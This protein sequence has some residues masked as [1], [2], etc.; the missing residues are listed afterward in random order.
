MNHRLILAVYSMLILFASGTGIAVSLDSETDTLAPSSPFI[1]ED[2]PKAM[3]GEGPLTEEILG[4]WLAEALRKT[5]IFLTPGA[6]DAAYGKLIPG[7][8]GKEEMVHVA[9]PEKNKRDRE[10][11]ISKAAKAYG[12]MQE[13]IDVL[14]NLNKDHRDKLLRDVNAAE[15]VVIRDHYTIA[16]FYYG[17]RAFRFRSRIYLP[18]KLLRRLNARQLAMLLVEEARHNK[19][20]RFHVNFQ[21]EPALLKA[22]DG[23]LVRYKKEVE[24]EQKE[25][26]RF[27]IR[28]RMRRE[29]SVMPYAVSANRNVPAPSELSQIKARDDDILVYS[30]PQHMAAQSGYDFRMHGTRRI[31]WGKIDD[32]RIEV[33]VVPS[34]FFSKASIK[35]LLPVLD[36]VLGPFAENAMPSAIRPELSHLWRRLDKAIDRMLASGNRAEQ[37][38]KIRS[39]FTKLALEWISARYAIEQLRSLFVQQPLPPEFLILAHEF[40]Q[41]PKGMMPIDTTQ[42]KSVTPEEM[43]KILERLAFNARVILDGRETTLEAAKV[44][45]AGIFYADKTVCYAI[46]RDHR[47]NRPAVNIKTGPILP[48]LSSDA[49]KKQPIAVQP[50]LKA[51]GLV[52]EAGATVTGKIDLMP[53]G[54]T[55]QQLDLHGIAEIS[56]QPSRGKTSVVAE[57]VL[58]LPHG[59]STPASVRVIKSGKE[60]LQEIDRPLDP[61]E[62]RVIHADEI[63]VSEVIRDSLRE[64][65]IGYDQKNRQ[66][67]DAKLEMGDAGEEELK[68]LGRHMDM[69]LRIKADHAVQ[70]AHEIIAAWPY[71]E[72]S[73]IRED[74]KKALDGARILFP[75]TLGGMLSHAGKR[76]ENRIY[77]PLPLMRQADTDGLAQEIAGQAYHLARGDWR[78]EQYQHPQDASIRLAEWIGYPQIQVWLHAESGKVPEGGYTDTGISLA[79]RAERIFYVDSV[80]AQGFSAVAAQSHIDSFCHSADQALPR[81]DLSIILINID[82]PNHH[83]NL[84]HALRRISKDDHVRIVFLAQREIRY[85]HGTRSAGDVLSECITALDFQEGVHFHGALSFDELLAMRQQGEELGQTFLRYAAE[86][87][88]AWAA[89]KG[90]S[91]DAKNIGYVNSEAKAIEL[92]AASAGILEIAPALPL[93]R[94]AVNMDHV[95]GFTELALRLR[96]AGHEDISFNELIGM[97][98]PAQRDQMRRTIQDMGVGDMA[99]PG[100]VRAFLSKPMAC[101]VGSDLDAEIHSFKQILSEA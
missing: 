33:Y 83:V 100:G 16:G 45:L 87:F 86:K 18:E 14:P 34:A 53:Q 37:A 98:K 6:K 92:N 49:A 13:I 79:S 51:E 63:A 11:L 29:Y 81:K 30:W 35:P 59:I 5:Q 101:P 89:G 68:L 91:I 71:P 1:S 74:I 4:A 77:V 76:F 90:Q 2:E 32:G 60:L 93:E 75:E 9:I 66:L 27:A 55:F 78:H 12:L 67:Y 8:N 20:D 17:H 47:G 94:Q 39:V 96:Q 23:I 21:H 84:R 46:S 72:D 43:V 73:T 38:L 56:S 7:K 62:K 22:I 48:L 24:L 52:M 31:H 26:L 25:A 40:A 85:V 42:Y 10:E 65:S 54:Q 44:A 70:K 82:D 99:Q 3:I 69:A 80:I 15:I 95:I 28:E 61:G 50:P 57:A 36:Q 97:L 41:T 58:P 88:G 64:G 19:D